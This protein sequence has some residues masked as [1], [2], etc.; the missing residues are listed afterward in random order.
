MDDGVVRT[1]GCY[2]AAFPETFDV[3]SLGEDLVASTNICFKNGKKTRML[4]R[5]S[6]S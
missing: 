3:S 4:P 2:S 1:G 6:A 5:I